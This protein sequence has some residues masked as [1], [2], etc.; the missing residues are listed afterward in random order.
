VA[1]PTRPGID[2]IESVRAASARG[3]RADRRTASQL[4]GGRSYIDGRWV[5]NLGSNNYLGLAQHPAIVEAVR[6]ALERYGA[7][8]GMNPTLALT[9]VHREL[10]DAVAEF[11]GMEA[12]ILFSSCT[13]ANIALIATLASDGDVVFSDRLNHASIID[14]CRLTRARTRVYGHADAADLARQLAEEREARLR[15]V[16][17]D[18]VFSM[19]G[20]AAPLP[21]L[22]PVARANAAIIVL[23][24]SHAAG[25]T[26]PGG[27]GTAAL[28]DA[29]GSV[30][31][32]TG[33]FS[34]ALGCVGGGYVAGSRAL[35]DLLYEDARFFIFTSPMTPS[36]A[37]GALAAMRVLRDDPSP[38]E[39]L[40]AN[41]ARFRRGLAQL[42]YRT[43][44]GPSAIVPVLIGDEGRAVALA[45]ALLAAGVFV[46]AMA[47]PIVPR[48]E[49]RL[50]A[51][52]SAAHTDDDIDAALAAFEAQLSG[53]A[54]A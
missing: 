21:S 2:E 22:V 1:T 11:T 20:D 46:P 24:E 38:H 53:A 6:E 29:R 39:R 52:P 41:V 14:A 36:A 45:R 12:A 50:R 42:G 54:S 34:K 17:S 28:H 23:D 44:D 25:T 27:R 5:V 43:I 40:R 3:R 18:G 8:T 51:Q 26:G 4:R 33:T 30:D 19:E 48:G 7:G 16:V 47:Y 32:E 49:A 10:E 9:A 37:A 35:A 15:L 13:A 31:V